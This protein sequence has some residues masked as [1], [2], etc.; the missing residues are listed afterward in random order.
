[1]DPNF[2]DLSAWNLNNPQQPNVG[3]PSI[4][5]GGYPGTN[6]GGYAGYPDSSSGSFTN[7]NTFG[8]SEVP[9][10]NIFP[11][12]TSDIYFNNTPCSAP[13]G[14]PEQRWNN[15]ND[16]FSNNPSYP[17][18]SY[19]NTTPSVPYTP[20]APTFKM[21]YGSGMQK[22]YTAGNPSFHN[23]QSNFS[24][25]PST[26]GGC[27]MFG[28]SVNTNRESVYPMF[29]D[30]PV[31]VTYQSNDFPGTSRGFGF[32][33]SAPQEDIPTA[34]HPS[35]HSGRYPNLAPRGY[36]GVPSI[37][38]LNV[39]SHNFANPNA[40]GYPGVQTEPTLSG[41]PSQHSNNFDVPFSSQL[42]HVNTSCS[43]TGPNTP[44]MPGTAL[45]QMNYENQMQKIYIAGNPGLQSPQLNYLSPPL[46]SGGCSMFGDSANT[47]RGSV[48]PMFNNF[49]SPT[50]CQSN[51]LSGTSRVLG[52]AES[53]SHEDIMEPTLK[54]A[55]NFCVERDC[56]H[57]KK[58][59]AGIG[60]KK[61][62]IIAV[63]GHRSVNQR[64]EIVKKYKS[65]Y[66]K[67]L[68]VK[69]KEELHN[70]LEDCLI[71]LCYSSVEF[72]A[73]ELRKAMSG[74]GTDEDVLIEILCSRTNEQI[75][76]I[77]D[78]YP[79]IYNG[80]NLEKDVKNETSR[81]F[82]R[83]CIA[84]L[85]AN[86]DESTSVDTNLV[87]RDVEDLYNAGE[88]RIGT[89]ESKFIHILVSR[90]YSH[91][92][93]VFDE[94]TSHGKRNMAD[95][96]K[97][98]MHGHTLDALLSIVRCIQS[99]PRYFAAKLLKAIKAPGTDDKTLIRIIV[100][101]CEVDMGQIKREFLSL[102]GKTLETCIHVSMNA[103]YYNCN[104]M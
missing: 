58:A 25:P 57:L 33:E 29:N 83:I 20:G 12:Q 30:I 22:P 34:I 35:M 64:V 7:S 69:F 59:M 75:R 95:A 84:L 102:N 55:P 87:R 46:L 97:S 88:S 96:L 51:S 92:R 11:G 63:M 93:A 44:Y 18:T 48:Y 101:R 15:P 41:Y 38:Y 37:G 19:P 68:L 1:M 86:R 72:D 27:S 79:K 103:N 60:S 31:P 66:G 65:M 40:N 54:A 73:T 78:I 81:H 77:K 89:D 52:F 21:D 32:A 67:D 47:N 8:Y 16:P 9:A 23:P 26:S 94:Y 43:T 90:S 70:H 24:V 28:D 17:N 6:T 80:R 62:E 36:P 74:A 53:A 61:K 3:Y 56:E 50:L 49:P 71:A 5:S 76:R 82:Q 91:L 42:G 99:K 100:S 45:F 4:P 39:P 85:Q 10:P 98:E 13:G 2:Q 104:T 14:F